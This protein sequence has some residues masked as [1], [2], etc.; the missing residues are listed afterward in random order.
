MRRL[1]SSLIIR[2]FFFVALVGMAPSARAQY[3]DLSPNSSCNDFASE[4]FAIGCNTYG[5]NTA[6]S[7]YAS[8]T[9]QA[10]STCEGDGAVRGTVYAY[11]YYAGPIIYAQASM[12]YS[13]FYNVS[14]SVEIDNTG[15]GNQWGSPAW[16]YC[17]SMGVSY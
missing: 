1:F 4:A 15:A 6:N 17:L 7:V 2:I 9:A 13:Y 16:D 5:F 3:W 8:M 10:T 11:G 14:M 12:S